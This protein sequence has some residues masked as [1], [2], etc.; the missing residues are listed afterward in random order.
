MSFLASA[1]RLPM[2]STIDCWGLIYSE[3]YTDHSLHTLK[4]SGATLRS[5]G[6]GMPSNKRI[7]SRFELAQK[8]CP[9]QFS[10]FVRPSELL[11]KRL[12]FSKKKP[13]TTLAASFQ[14][15]TLSSAS[16]E[17]LVESLNHSTSQ[18]FSDAPYH[19]FSLVHCLSLFQQA[20]EIVTSDR[21]VLEAI[22]SS[23]TIQFIS[24]LPSLLASLSLFRDRS[25][26]QLLRQ[27]IPLL[28]SL[29][30]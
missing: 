20:W 24:I 14:P 5:L 23:Y 28:L 18:G 27:E 21:W 2:R 15:S 29:G 8:S 22:T 19:P 26:D 25:H 10:T 6:I 13:V 17:G 11:A 7:F 4:D 12:R 30:T 1:V 3:L 16:C 9:T